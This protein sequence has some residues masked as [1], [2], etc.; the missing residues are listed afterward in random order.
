MNQE[1]KHILS[2][3][4]RNQPGVMSHISGL[5]TRRVF[6]IDSIAV[7]VTD[8]PK[9]SSMTIILSGDDAALN[10]L[11][12]QLLKLA[13]VLEIKVLPYHN[14]VTREL[15][16]MRI[17]AS[18]MQRTELFGIVE[19]FKGRVLEITE[20]SMLIESHGNARHMKSLIASLVPFGILEL[21]R[22]GQVALA[23]SDIGYLE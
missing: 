23:F 12:R 15:I 13:D 10:Q 2:I 3:Y 9:V 22:T 21:A 8:N 19:V 17:K 14:S 1:K 11:H 5:F 4:V 20:D 16:L 6:N 18:N 7:G